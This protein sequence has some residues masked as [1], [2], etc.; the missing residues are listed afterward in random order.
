MAVSCVL[1]VLTVVHDVDHVRQGR[2]LPFELYGVAVLALVMV[3]TTLTMLVRSHPLAEGAAVVLGILTIVGVG[4][5]H[6]A[7]EW[8]TH[9]DSY[10]AAHADALSWAIIIAMVLAGVVLAVVAA[11]SHRRVTARG[12]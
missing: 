5:V 11:V 2:A 8:S 10:G 7:P 3:G 1:G 6:V 12:G 4:A 9:A